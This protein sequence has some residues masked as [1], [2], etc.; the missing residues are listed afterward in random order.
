VIGFVMTSQLG[1]TLLSGST[2]SEDQ[3]V[4]VGEEFAAH[5]ELTTIIARAAH[6]RAEEAKPDHGPDD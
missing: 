1:R 4:V 5:D 2:G 3:Q 6:D